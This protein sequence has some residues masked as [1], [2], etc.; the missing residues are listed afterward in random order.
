MKKELTTVV[1][2]T[3]RLRLVKYFNVTEIKTEGRPLL[4]LGQKKNINI[5]LN[6]SNKR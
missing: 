6:D 5:T 2:S 3:K 4:Y 1:V